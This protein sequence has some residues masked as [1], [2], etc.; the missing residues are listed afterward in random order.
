MKVPKINPAL[1]AVGVF[2]AV[3]VLVGGVT[4]AVLTSN[5]ATL[6]NNTINSATA[7]MV[8]S[9]DAGCGPSAGV[10][11][12]TDTGFA[13]NGLV[14]GGAA[15]PNETFCIK[16]TGTAD[17]ALK[18]FVPTAPTWTVTPSGT[19]D[20]GE[21]DVHVDCGSGTR[22]LD[23]TVE[24]LATS[25]QAF[26]GSNLTAGATTVCT[27]NIDMNAAAFTGSGA[28]SGNFNF[29]FSGEGA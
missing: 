29:E 28:S 21:V 11:G 7:S 9:S 13:F 5:T 3:V 10:F 14:P 1:R 19:V 17:L 4:Y 20:N 6:T 24:D 15:S 25:P 18:L 2:S 27:I 16:N 23:A 8:V 22:T 12:A 26:T